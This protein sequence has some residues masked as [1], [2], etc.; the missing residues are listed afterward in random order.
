MAEQFTTGGAYLNKWKFNG[1]EL[2]AETGLYYYGARYYDPRSS[3]WLGVDPLGEKHP[4]MSPYAYC[5][6]NP[7]NLIDPDGRDWYKDADGTYQ[8]NKD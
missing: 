2:D 8:Y 7:I 4:N 1:K 5:A 3:V 6:N